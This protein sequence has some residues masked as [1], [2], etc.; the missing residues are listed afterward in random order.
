[1]RA[2]LPSLLRPYVA[3]LVRKEGVH[4]T[5]EASLGIFFARVGARA[6][7]VFQPKWCLRG[8]LEFSISDIPEFWFAVH[9]RLLTYVGYYYFLGSHTSILH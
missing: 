9:R 1:M 8:N 3:Y 6:P 5:S 4:F 7:S 2:F